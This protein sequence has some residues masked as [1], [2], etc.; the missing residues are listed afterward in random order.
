VLACLVEGSSN[1][2]IAQ[3]LDIAPKTVMHHTVAIYRKLGAKGRAEA[4]AMGERFGVS[5]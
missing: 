1:E 2:E 5:R 4:A 3:R